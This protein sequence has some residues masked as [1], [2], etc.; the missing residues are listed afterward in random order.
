MKFLVIGCGSIGK[1]HIGNL[2]TLSVNDMIASDVRL[3]R[4]D[5]VEKAYGIKTYI[6]IEEAFEQKPDVALIASP[7]RLH[8]QQALVAARKG[9]H[10]FVEKPLS[11]VLDGV[12]ELIEVAARNSLTTL[13]GC[14]MRF[15][16]PISL[17]K[18][19]LDSGGVGGVI[20]ARL[21][22]GFYLPDWHPWE[23]YH[24]SYSANRGLGGGV[25]LDGIHEIDY[26]RWF[27]GDVKQVFCFGGK[28]S[29][30]EID[31]EDTAE[32]LFKFETGAIAEVH[33]DYIQRARG[34]SCQL[35]GDKGTIIWDQSDRT[36]KLYSAEVKHWQVYPESFD[37]NINEMYLKEMQHFVKCI[38]NKENSIND[39]KQAK[40]V[41]EIALAAKESARTGQIINLS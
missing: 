33:L 28:L 1:R 27:L 40:R 24:Q 20:S 14:N 34:R 15:Y 7:T 11:H 36:V 37:A 19:L 22:A 2:I 23:D 26:I 16:A 29:D 13:V 21:Q 41:L 39:L 12:D 32:I 31:V 25:I 4:L 18:E 38:G 10:L 35:I 8:V 30:L 17:M 3:D 9:C 6:N 5:E